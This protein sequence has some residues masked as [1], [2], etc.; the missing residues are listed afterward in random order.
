MGEDGAQP[1]HIEAQAM[2]DAFASVGATCF[3]VTW[4]NSKGAPRKYEESVSLEDLTRRLPA[5]LDAAISQQHNLIVR[6]RGPGRT[7][8]QLDD[9]KIDQITRVAPAV[10]LALETSPGNFQAWVATGSRGG[11]GF[12]APLEKGHRGGQDREWR[13]ACRRKP[14]LQGQI[15]PRLSARSDSSG[16]FRPTGSCWRA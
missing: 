2:L 8:I 10:F 16:E 11:Q 1:S 4:T 9:L 3:D 6:P 15:R 5:L 7:F 12:C 14:Q 13:N